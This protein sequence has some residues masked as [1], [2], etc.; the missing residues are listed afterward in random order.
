M[1]IQ[2]DLRT[3]PA[4]WLY[5]TSVH[6]SVSLCCLGLESV[7]GALTPVR[8]V[9]ISNKNEEQKNLL[10]PLKQR[11][12]ALVCRYLR[13][14]SARQALPREGCFLPGTKNMRMEKKKMEKN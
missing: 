10:K 14:T 11:L 3:Y 12:L 2:P 1:E 5:I 8:D 6:V 7:V 13:S 4:M 9:C